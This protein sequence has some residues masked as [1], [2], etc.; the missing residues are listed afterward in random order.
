MMDNSS[1][2]EESQYFDA[3]DQIIE[4]PELFCDDFPFITNR[5]YDVWIHAPQSVKERRREFV[6]LMRLD[7]GEF[8]REN[9]AE[10]C[11]TS[12]DAP[13]DIGDSRRIMETSGAVLRFPEDEFS[14]SRWNTEDLGLRECRNGNSNFNGV[15]ECIDDGTVER[16]QFESSSRFSPS[17]EQ[18]VLREIKDNASATRMENKSKTS[19]LRKLRLMTCMAGRSDFSRVYETRIQKI[20]VR[21]S[22]RRSKEFSALFTGQDIEA[23]KGAIVAMKFSLDGKYLA[24]AG[25]DK[26]VRI[27][28]VV[29]DERLNMDD[30]DIPDLDPSC[31][32][33]SANNLSETGPLT[34]ET[35]KISKSKSSGF[36]RMRESACVVFPPKVFRIHEKPLHVFEGHEGEILDLS[37]SHDNCLLSSSVDKT[38]RLWRVGVDHCLKVFLHS[39]YVTSIHFNPVNDDCFISGSIDGKVRIWAIGDC[40]VV[41]WTEITDIITAVCYR[42]DG[43]SGMIGSITGTCRN[44]DLS[45]N[46]F[47]LGA[48][49]CITSKKKSPSKRIMSFQFSPRDPSKILVTCADSKVRVIDGVNVIGKYKGLRNGGNQISASF[50]SDGKHIISASDDSNI[51][52]WNYTSAQSISKPKTIR[53]FECFLSEASIAIPWPGPKSSWSDYFSLSHEYF[54]NPLSKGSAT[55]PEEKLPVTTLTKSQ[56]KLFKNS[57]QTSSGS[58]AWGLV[59]VSA[60]LDGRI[61]SFHNYGLPVSL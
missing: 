13:F 61:R 9:S 26:I 12:K 6:R 3:V 15:N 1:N 23:H 41:G 18:F 4:E 11:E 24:S 53:S 2:C 54:H 20:R 58:H 21:H 42:P 32:Y 35:D 22:W 40:K 28:Q 31:V 39:D 43:Q 60:G 37:W 25:E 38:V 10:I 29:E 16:G 45:D 5:E 19:W 48:Q 8:E 47:Q 36:R 14:S 7:S 52:I 27:W 50:T 55:W 59:I 49:V 56:Y 30:I 57:C 44:F 17:V 34:V 33:F 46:H 51:Y